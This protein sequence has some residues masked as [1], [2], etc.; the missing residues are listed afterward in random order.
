MRLVLSR[1]PRGRSG[2]FYKGRPVRLPAIGRAS[3]A[4]RISPM[5]AA[6]RGPPCQIIAVR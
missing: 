6:A 5:G 3:Q 1:E 4:A 2:G